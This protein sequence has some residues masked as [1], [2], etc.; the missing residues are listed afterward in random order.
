MAMAFTCCAISPDPVFNITGNKVVGMVL[1][2]LPPYKVA[3]R[4]QANSHTWQ[5]TCQ[6][7]L[8]GLNNT[9]KRITSDFR[10]V[11]TEGYRRKRIA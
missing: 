11:E 6:I 7:L 1:G 9:P 10:I 5:T 2:T 4:S 3:I 8:D